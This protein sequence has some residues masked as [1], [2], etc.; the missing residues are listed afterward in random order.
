LKR[1]EQGVWDGRFRVTLAHAPKRNI[2]KMEVRAL[3]PQGVSALRALGLEEPA[4]APKAAFPALPGLWNGT[5]LVAAPH[6]GTV[7]P[8]YRLEAVP[9]ASGLFAVP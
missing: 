1:G 8:S 5:V 7:S 2:A 3:G 9:L 6:F 4:G